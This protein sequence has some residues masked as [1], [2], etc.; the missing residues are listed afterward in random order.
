M[1]LVIVLLGCV[2]PSWAKTTPPRFED[3]HVR[4]TFHNKTARLVL[5]GDARYY[6]TRLREASHDTVNIGGHYIVAEWGC[7]AVCVMG[8]II[9]A[10]TGKIMMLPNVCCYFNYLTDSGY[11]YDPHFSPLEYRRDSKLIILRGRLGEEGAMQ[12]NYYVIEGDRL[13]HILSVP[14]ERV[15]AQ[16]PEKK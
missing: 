3:Y 11:T 2:H 9:D 12:I 10:R 15:V 14:A 4:E 16:V 6:R 13:K 7:G 5:H 8:G 1:Y